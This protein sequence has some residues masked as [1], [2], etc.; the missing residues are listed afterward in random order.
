MVIW[1]HYRQT[2]DRLAE[3]LKYLNPAKIYGGTAD[4]EGQ[5]RMFREDK[6]C[7]LMIANTMSVGVGTN[8]T[9]ANY[10][11]FFE[12]T[13]DLDN[14]DQA[15]SRCRRPGQQ[16]KLWVRNYAVK[17]SMESRKILPRLIAK[18]TFSKRILQDKDAFKDFIAMGVDMEDYF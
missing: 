6:D 12:Y 4:F 17:N 2:I 3:E 8:F 14:Y 11:A 7:H 15:I 1:A 9:V 18:K 10:M 5:K 13:F 16:H